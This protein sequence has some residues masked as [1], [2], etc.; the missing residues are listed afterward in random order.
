MFLSN[1]KPSGGGATYPEIQDKFA[2]K[3]GLSKEKAE[4]F[5]GRNP[6]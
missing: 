6:K 4:R 2:I 3:R 1:Q 5:Y